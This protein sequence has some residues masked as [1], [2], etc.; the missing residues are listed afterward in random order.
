MYFPFYA[1]SKTRLKMAYN[2][3]ITFRKAFIF[4]KSVKFKCLEVWLGKQTSRRLEL[5]IRGD[6]WRKKFA[7]VVF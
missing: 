7:V 4:I 1:I 5:P 6:K 2:A 3:K